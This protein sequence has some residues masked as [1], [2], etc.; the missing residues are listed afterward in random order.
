MKLVY[1]TKRCNQADVVHRFDVLG[2]FLPSD[3]DVI[4]QSLQLF[5][6]QLSKSGNICPVIV[7]DFSESTLRI[8]EAKL[9]RF[10]I[11]MRTLALASRV[12]LNIAQ[13]DI[14]SMHAEQKSIEQA[15]HAKL[16][17]LEN[18]LDLVES[19]KNK[20]EQ[21]THENQQL[22]EQLL[23]SKPKNSARTIF[24]KLWGET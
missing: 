23:E 8:N 24:E 15:L 10:V 18:K 21:F 19:T 20:I 17:V 6:N 3:L 14:E 16:S 11:E 12:F 9:Q 5:F 13:S 22:R 1:S 2:E 7:L 4:K